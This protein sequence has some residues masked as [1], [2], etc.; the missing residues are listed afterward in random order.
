MSPLKLMWVVGDV[1]FERLGRL[2]AFFFVLFSFFV[3]FFAFICVFL[4][5]GYCF[6]LI[7]ALFLL[8]LSPPVPFSMAGQDR[9][10]GRF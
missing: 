1:S 7:R 2:G 8:L 3:F 9:A 5:E 6:D 4:G 10:G